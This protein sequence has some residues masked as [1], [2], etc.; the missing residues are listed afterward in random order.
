M[1][2]RQ[3]SPEACDRPLNRKSLSELRG[4]EFADKTSTLLADL[5]SRPA[6]REG[7]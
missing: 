2:R 4:A 1:P 5:S 3:L 7:A 6:D